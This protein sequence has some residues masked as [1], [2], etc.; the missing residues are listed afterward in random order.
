MIIKHAHAR[1]IG[2]CNRGLR[3]WFEKREI[4]FSE[5][6]SSGVTI[7]WALAQN[8]AMMNALVAYVFSLPPDITG[9]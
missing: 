6:L 9:E 1:Q 3:L 8:D 2:Y 7:T 4:T 5:F